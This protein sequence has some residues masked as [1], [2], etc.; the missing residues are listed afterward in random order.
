MTISPEAKEAGFRELDCDV[1]T[2]THVQL[3]INS[4][5]APLESKINELELR[6]KLRQERVTTHSDRCHLWHIDC[7]VG[8]LEAATKEI[9]RLSGEVEKAYREGWK[10]EDS[11]GVYDSDYK[12]SRARRVA[13]GKE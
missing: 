13:E 1:P 7:A 3:A 8:R 10:Q 2:G 12:R 9:E 5:T 4:A 6:L 11:T